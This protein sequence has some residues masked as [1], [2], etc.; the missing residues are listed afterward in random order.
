V[1][2]KY[3]AKMAQYILVQLHSLNNTMAMVSVFRCQEIQRTACD[4]PIG[5]ELRTEGL[6]RVD[7]RNQMV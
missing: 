7:H 5:R 1:S 3:I 6:S 4:E 2:H